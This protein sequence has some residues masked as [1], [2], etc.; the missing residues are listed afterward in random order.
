MY[1]NRDDSAVS[2]QPYRHVLLISVTDPW[3]PASKH[4]CLVLAIA[5]HDLGPHSICDASLVELK[6]RF[7]LSFALFSHAPPATERQCLS[8]K[9]E[10]QSRWPYS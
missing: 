9:A 2:V 8:T 10:T 4:M 1:A 3:S 5:R 7:R 6:M